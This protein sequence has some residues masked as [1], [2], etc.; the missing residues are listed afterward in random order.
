MSIWITNTTNCG[1]FMCV[2]WA[3]CPV[4]MTDHNDFLT[5]Q[6]NII[7]KQNQRGIYLVKN[8]MK[9]CVRYSRFSRTW[10]ALSIELCVRFPIMR[11][12]KELFV[13]FLS[14]LFSHPFP[15]VPYVAVSSMR[16]L[17][18]HDVFAKSEC[19]PIVLYMQGERRAGNPNY[20]TA[21]A[22]TGSASLKNKDW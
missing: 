12:V 4:C 16:F 17:E 10:Y 2:I 1:S 13:A 18:F 9:A 11:I 21:A 22:V 14:G 15:G 6:S 5:I 20:N 7:L 3:V 19:Y 8:N